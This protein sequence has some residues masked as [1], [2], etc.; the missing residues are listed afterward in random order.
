M[1][2]QL[3]AQPAAGAEELR[4]R[5]PRLDAEDLA[6][7]LVGVALQVVQQEDRA[8]SLGE[9]VDRAVEILAQV[10]FDPG[11]GAGA[12]QLIV[13]RGLAGAEALDAPQLIQ[14]H[15]RRDRR[16]PGPE[17]R[18]AAEGGDL[19]E[20]AHECLLREVLGEVIVTRKPVAEPED[21]VDVQVVQRPRD[22]VISVLQTLDELRFRH[23]V[24]S[25]LPRRV[26]RC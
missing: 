13:Q 12:H 18:F 20:C 21:P 1:N 22:P 23:R 9:V 16:D 8:V 25:P 24:A 5:G 11:R 26:F 3:L 2:G 17:R 14:R 15:G 10:G 7:L 19:R 6:D 4:L